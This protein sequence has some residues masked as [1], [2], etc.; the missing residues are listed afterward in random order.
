[1]T[2]NSNVLQRIHRCLRDSTLFIYSTTVSS[3]NIYLASICS[4][5]EKETI[6]SVPR[7]L[8]VTLSILAEK[9]THFDY[10]NNRFVSSFI[11]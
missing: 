10:H 1:M 6:L 9:E 2:R 11:I 3:D 8:V 5:C 4:N 7:K